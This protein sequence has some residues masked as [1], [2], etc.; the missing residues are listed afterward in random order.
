MQE[1]SYR[2]NGLNRNYRFMLWFGVFLIGLNHGEHKEHG[3]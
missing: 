3:G 1:L 2:I